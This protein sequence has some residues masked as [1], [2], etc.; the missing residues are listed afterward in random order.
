MTRRAAFMIFVFFALLFMGAWWAYN[1]VSEYFME[2]T[3]TADRL[4]KPYGE[5]VYR[6]AQKIERGQ[7]ISA[8]AVKDLPGGVNA[9]YGEEITL[10]FHAVGGRNVAAI[11]TLLGA[12]A[13]PYMIDRP[14]QGSRRDFAYYLTLPG[15]PTDPNLGFPF[16][17]QLIRLYLK[18][19]GDPNHRAGDAE[20][21]PLIAD[22]ALIDNYEG[23]NIL[24]EAK[25]DPWQLSSR[26][27]NAMNRLAADN[28]SQDELNKLIDHGYFDGIPLNKLQDFFSWLSLYTPRGDEITKAN[29]EIGLR[30]LKRNPNYSPDD[31]TRRLFQGDI[32]WEKVKLAR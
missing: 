20:R 28:L 4:F 7:P 1:A 29:Q 9:R 8:S 17:N 25:A 15:H 5:D 12:G 13:D 32:P 2:P 19:G 10:L 24:L 26:N 30:V 11:D 3:Y 18:H 6:I 16:I 27:Q 21:T 14:S 31:N 22:V 23:V